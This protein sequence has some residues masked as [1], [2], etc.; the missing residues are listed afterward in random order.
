[1]K[2]LLDQY[3]HLDS[4]LHRWQG[5][6]KFIAFFSLIFSF[7]FVQKLSLLPLVIIITFLLFYISKLP[8]TFLLSRL[9]YPGIFI[10]GVI[11]VLPF[12]A[13]ETV[14]FSWGFLSIKSEGILTVI[15]I[16][17]RFV[18]ILT[19]SLVLFGTAPFLVTL[20]T[21]KSLGLSP[22]LNDMML[23]TYRYLEEISNRLL[24]MRRALKLKGFNGQKLTL[25][26]LQIIANLISS[27]LI[28]SYDQS[29]LV[30][31]AMIL[32]GYGYD[33][34]DKKPIKEEINYQHW[35]NCGVMVTI[36]ALLMVLQWL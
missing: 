30:Y 10:F 4:P 16:V 34:P 11:L 25:R 29:K 6:S 24:M 13:G 23:L 22:I 7:A 33:S 28:R 5:K 15:L 19:I 27:L 31:Q 18:C 21:L 32:R 12:F 2:L 26:N 8:L 36:S 20:K 35:F 1:M 17:T 9:K 3:A 14:I